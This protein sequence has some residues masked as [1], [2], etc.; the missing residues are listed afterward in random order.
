MDRTHWKVR[1][2]I[3]QLTKSRGNAN[4][5]AGLSWEA[6]DGHTELGSAWTRN[7]ALLVR[8]GFG[9]TGTTGKLHY[10]AFAHE[11]CT[12]ESRNNIASIHGIF[13]FDEAESVHELDLGNFAVSMGS[14]VAL[15]IS[16]GSYSFQGI[17]SARRQRHG[18]ESKQRWVDVPGVYQVAIQEGGSGSDIIPL[19]GRL[20]R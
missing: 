9:A 4:L 17:Q 14:E 19:R 7:R 5:P 13:V 18:K 12:M 3:V 16:A 6:V 11:V 10:E 1:Q 8:I 20:P 15:H 2:D